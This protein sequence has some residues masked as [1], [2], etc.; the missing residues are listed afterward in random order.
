MT[1]YFANYDAGTLLL[2]GYYHTDVPIPAPE[3]NREITEAEWTAAL[4]INA[5]QFDNNVDWNLVYIPI[6]FTPS[7]EAEALTSECLNYL[8]DSQ[9]HLERFN[10]TGELVPVNIAV[11]RVKCFT[12]LGAIDE[13]VH[14]R[15]D[16]LP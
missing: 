5:N 16:T 4:A 13:P 12:H 8:R 14:A 2:L 1:Q 10:E 11:N 15:I 9:Y 7:E 3:P 6:P